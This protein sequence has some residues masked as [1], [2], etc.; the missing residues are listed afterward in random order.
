[1]IR[2]VKFNDGCHSS[3]MGGIILDNGDII[4]GYNGD[5]I[6]RQMQREN[7]NFKILQVYDWWVDISEDILEYND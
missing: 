5:I 2:Q 6:T 7:P 4:C 3:A 1:M